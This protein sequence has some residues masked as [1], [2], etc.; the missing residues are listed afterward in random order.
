MTGVY[1]LTTVLLDR[2]SAGFQPI[3]TTFAIFHTSAHEEG[4]PL[5]TKLDVRQLILPVVI[6]HAISENSIVS[7]FS[8]L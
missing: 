1:A 7:M 6:S 8:V 2:R 5:E 3:L 4:L